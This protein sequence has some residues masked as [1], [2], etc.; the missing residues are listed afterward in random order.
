MALCGSILKQSVCY[1][2]QATTFSAENYV[3]SLQAVVGPQSKPTLPE[4]ND[5]S[6]EMHFHSSK[7]AVIQDSLLIQE[8]HQQMLMGAPQASG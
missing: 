3:A 8:M 5:A 6:A 2:S 4:R 7:S 1:D